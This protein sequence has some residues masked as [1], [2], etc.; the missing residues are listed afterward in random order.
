MS[1]VPS[2]QLVLQ[3]LMKNRQKRMGYVINVTVL[4]CA[5]VSWREGNT[6]QT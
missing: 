5:K 1:A 2:S 3:L 6:I 4:P